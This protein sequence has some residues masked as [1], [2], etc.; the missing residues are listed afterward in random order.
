VKGERVMGSGFPYWRCLQKVTDGRG[1]TAE[2]GQRRTE[3]RE[4]HGVRLSL[5]ALFTEV[6]FTEGGIF[7]LW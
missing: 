5:L 4:C 6:F 2:D 1:R 7:H 3:D